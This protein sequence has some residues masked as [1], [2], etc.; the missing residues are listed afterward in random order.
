MHLLNGVKL[1]ANAKLNLSLCVDGR[2]SDDFHGV[3]TVV[4]PILLHDTIEITATPNTSNKIE[5]ISEFIPDPSNSNT[6][7]SNKK[8]FDILNSPK[9]LA[10]QAASLFLDIINSKYSIKIKLLKAIPTQAGLGGGSSDAAT[11]L[12]GLSQLIRKTANIDPLLL[13]LA[14]KLGSDV[15]ALLFG[16]IIFL[17]GR[18]EKH[19]QLNIHK[20]SNFFDF[21][22][23]LK[24]ILV[25]PEIGVD[26]AWAY[27]SL[28]RQQIL[29]PNEEL[30]IGKQEESD[31]FES[32]GISINEVRESFIS[33][34]CN[35]KPWVND[36]EPTIRQLVPEVDRA[37]NELYSLGAK[38]VILAG[39]GSCVAGVF[40]QECD[41]SSVIS[42]LRNNL[43]DTWFIRE[44]RFVHTSC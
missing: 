6:S 19:C 10:Y 14:A 28:R 43:D 42:N 16:D 8:E 26:T 21:L 4:C 2:I 35:L 12:L 3:R 18:G 11:V 25:K 29:K 7:N 1:K 13:E 32:M 31:S 20:S 37:F 44:S 9:N 34:P 41:V 33:K 39:S 24:L 27:K 23:S 5:I 15:V 17:H 36:F 30:R 40:M 38:K 22:N